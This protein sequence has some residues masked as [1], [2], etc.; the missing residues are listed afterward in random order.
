MKHVRCAVLLLVL[1]GCAT[2]PPPSPVP[3]FDAAAA[4]ATIRAAGA[5]LPTELDVQPLQDPLVTDLREQARADEQAGRFDNAA[6][7]LDRALAERPDDPAV[8]Q[9]RAEL[10]LLQRQPD[11]AFDFAQRARRVGPTVGPLCRR[12]ME[13]LLQVERI[14]AQA[15]DDAATARADALANER[16]ACTVKPPPRY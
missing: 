10:A 5:E 13:T 2:S 15:G 3:A 12:S 1:A 11:A 6:S 16:D 8:L 9:E 4:V 14:R 7:A